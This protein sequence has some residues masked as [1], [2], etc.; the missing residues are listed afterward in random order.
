M[1]T[2]L[3]SIAG[4]YVGWLSEAGNQCTVSAEFNGKSWYH[5]CNSREEAKKA[6]YRAAHR[7]LL[8][9]WLKK[10]GISLRFEEGYV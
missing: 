4:F 3:F 10:I 9:K 2:E 1:A 8:R 5:R 6:F 7:A